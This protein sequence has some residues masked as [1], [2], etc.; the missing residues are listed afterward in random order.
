MSKEPAAKQPNHRRW[1]NDTAVQQADPSSPAEGSS[2]HYCRPRTCHQPANNMSFSLVNR[3]VSTASTKVVNARL[4][5]PAFQQT[6]AIT[7]H[8]K[9]RDEG[10]EDNMVS[11]SVVV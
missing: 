9:T 4:A 5:V 7:D 8:W 1:P 11:V 2:V 6:R 10:S 3:V